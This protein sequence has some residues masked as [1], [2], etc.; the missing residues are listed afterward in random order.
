MLVKVCGLT[1][2][3]NTEEVLTLKP[4]MAGLILYKNSKR[5]AGDNL[6]NQSNLIKASGIPLVFVLVNPSENEVINLINQYS[7]DYIQ[8]HG[9]ESVYICSLIKNMGAKVIKAIQVKRNDDVRKAIRYDGYADILLFDTACTNYG[10]SGTRFNWKLLNE[11]QGHANFLLSGGISLAYIDK[12]LDINHPQ[13]IG[14][15]INSGFEDSTGIKNT[16]SI[17][18]LMLKLKHKRND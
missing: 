10:G 5:Y 18:Q 6:N 3:D 17:S 9:Y 15:D 7:P 14:I 8:L 2:T 13:L 12:I 11:Y 1:Q 16:D 4:D